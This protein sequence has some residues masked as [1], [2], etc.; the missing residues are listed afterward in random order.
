M[1]ADQQPPPMLLEE[2]TAV[3]QAIAIVHQEKH[4]RPSERNLNEA[5]KF[6]NSDLSSSSAHAQQ[7]VESMKAA[8]DLRSDLIMLFRFYAAYMCLQVEEFQQNHHVILS[9][10]AMQVFS[11]AAKIMDPQLFATSLPDVGTLNIDVASTRLAQSPGVFSSFHTQAAISEGDGKRAYLK[12]FG[13]IQSWLA[14]RSQ[15]AR[16]DLYYIESSN[17]QYPQRLHYDRDP[18][19]S[20]SYE[21]YFLLYFPLSG[22]LWVGGGTGP[23]KREQVPQNGA[24]FGHGSRCLHGAAAYPGKNG[25]LF[26]QTT[27]RT[28]EE[29]DGERKIFFPNPN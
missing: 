15:A 27:T 4:C 8:L 3:L 29:E 17:T 18:E 7:R 19:S 24:F 6:F 26:W 13:L 12:V 10:W 11:T 16:D 14:N 5:W 2:L 9:P 21:E 1:A 28:E 22:A 20:E 25:R 23:A